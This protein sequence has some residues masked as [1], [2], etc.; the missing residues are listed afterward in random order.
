MWPWTKKVAPGKAAAD[1]LAGDLFIAEEEQRL[2]AL[3]EQ[4]DTSRQAERERQRLQDRQWQASHI[5]KPEISDP[6][7]RRKPD[8]GL[9]T[10]L[11]KHVLNRQI[12]TYQV[13]AR[14]WQ[15]ESDDR[16]AERDKAKAEREH[17]KVQEARQREQ[18]RRDHQEQI[19]REQAR[20]AE[21][22]AARAQAAPRPQTQRLD[23]IWVMPDQSRSPP[24]V[25]G[26][27]KN[28]PPE[29]SNRPRYPEPIRREQNNSVFGTHSAPE[30]EP[31]QTRGRR[32]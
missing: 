23:G 24:E 28:N 11:G 21:E 6:F 17:A 25:S 12:H 7:F 2:H 20:Q 31:Q 27:L 4:N 30:P 18:Q 32:R 22:R 16:R 10:R 3:R 29:T 19:K 14:R 13:F 1:K 8:E 26:G 9:L 5:W 15:F